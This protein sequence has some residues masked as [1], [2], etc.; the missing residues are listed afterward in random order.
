MHEA[1]D[2]MK[3]E[4]KEGKREEGKKIINNQDIRFL[5]VVTEPSVCVCVPFL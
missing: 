2:S 3:V 1:L 4:K 5:R